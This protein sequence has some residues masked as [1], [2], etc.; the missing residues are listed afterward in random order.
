MITK[1]K[2]LPPNILTINHPPTVDFGPPIKAAP[3][4]HDPGQDNCSALVQHLFSH[5]KCMRF[6]TKAEVAEWC[7]SHIKVDIIWQLN[8]TTLMNTASTKLYRLCA[9]ECMV[10]GH[11]FNHQ[12]RHKKILNLKNDLRGICSCKT[13]FLRFL[14]SE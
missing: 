2:N 5:V 6:N 7:G 12:H 10:I 1:I 4:H 13:R 3:P 8:P 9:A 11:N 14:Q